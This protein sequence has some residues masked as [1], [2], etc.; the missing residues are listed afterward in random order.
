[1]V[2]YSDSTP[3]IVELIEEISVLKGIAR[4]I[5]PSSATNK[6]HSIKKPSRLFTDCQQ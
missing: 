5:V 4:M 2:Q 6:R 3:N 1:W